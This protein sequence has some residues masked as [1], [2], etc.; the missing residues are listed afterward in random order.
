MEQ[1]HV[2]PCIETN[3]TGISTTLKRCFHCHSLD[4]ASYGMLRS[5]PPRIYSPQELLL[6]LTG[7]NRLQM[8]SYIR[9]HLQQIMSV[10]LS[11]VCLSVVALGQTE[12]SFGD[13]AADPVKLFE[14]GQNAHARGEFEKALDYYERAI[15]IRPEFAEAEFQRGNALVGLG[16]LDV[17]QTAFERAIALRKA[18]S[19]PYSA[20]G[21]LLV[22]EAKDLEAE[23]LFRQALAVDPQ[24][25]VALRML[26][27]IRLRSGDPKEALAL[28]QQATRDQNASTGSWIVKAMAERVN[29]DHSAARTSLAHALQN[30]PDNV[31]G[32]LERAELYLDEKDYEHAIVDLNHALKSRPD[33]KH[34]LARLAFAYQQAGKPEDAQRYAERAGIATSTP[35]STAGIINVTGTPDEIQ[36]ANSDDSATSRKALEKLLGKNPR[37]AMLLARLGAS[38]RS[39]NPSRSLDY[40]SRAAAL[41]PGNLEY[42]TGYAAALVQAR[43]FA[44]AATLL[45]RVIARSPQHYTAHA[46]LATALYELKRFAEALPEYEWLLVVKPDLVVAYYFIATAHD[47]LGEYPEALT[48]YETFLLRADPTTNKLEI[49]KVKLRLPGLRKQIQLGEGVKRKK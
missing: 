37:N 16:R 35:S 11:L 48:A 7:S 42:A 19:L 39:D 22:R 13:A 40:Y 14:Q 31:T 38:Y 10:F 12:D 29:G 43:R 17:A 4:A 33:D 27:E 41:E 26:A 25:N 1:R 49:E 8:L 15:Q 3:A 36:A 20:L 18:W 2:I 34:T 21:A 46:N 32:L 47:Y 5:K 9:S 23:R 6:P 45:S 44:E 24:D 28:A 30:D